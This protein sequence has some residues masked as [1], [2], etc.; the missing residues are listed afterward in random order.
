MPAA[1]TQRT[2]FDRFVTRHAFALIGLVTFI[3]ITIFSGNLWFL[4]GSAVFASAILIT[5][6]FVDY[7]TVYVD[8]DGTLIG[9]PSGPLSTHPLINK[10]SPL[11]EDKPKKTRVLFDLNTVTPEQP[12]VQ[13]QEDA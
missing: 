3:L 6:P 7:T 9:T 12:N 10:L 13:T 4:T 11:G 8:D 1:K 5:H 2:S